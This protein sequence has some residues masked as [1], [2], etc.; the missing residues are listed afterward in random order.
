MVSPWFHRIKSHFFRISEAGFTPRLNAL[1]LAAAVAESALG[2]LS[3]FQLGKKARG[4]RFSHGLK[5][6]K[7]DWIFDEIQHPANLGYP[8]DYGNPHM[9][10]S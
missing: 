6:D 2:V 1:R 7:F 8:G 5:Y 3:G 10:V 9:K 4:L